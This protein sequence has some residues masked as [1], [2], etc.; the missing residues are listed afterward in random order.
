MQDWQVRPIEWTVWGCLWPRLSQYR[1][2]KDGF[3]VVTTKDETGSLPKRQR[4]FRGSNEPVLLQAQRPQ[5]VADN[6][7][8]QR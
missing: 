4:N 3:S 5:P 1:L 8:N 7:T 6:T 2:D